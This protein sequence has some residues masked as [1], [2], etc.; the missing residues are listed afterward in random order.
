M[1]C[2][3]EG[4]PPSP[5]YGDLIGSAEDAIKKIRKLE[6]ELD[7]CEN[8]NDKLKEELKSLKKAFKILGSGG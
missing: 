8:N 6:R 1:P 2:S 7:E 4:F 5:C 3:C